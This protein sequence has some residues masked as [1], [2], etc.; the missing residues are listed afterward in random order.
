MKEILIRHVR[1]NLGMLNYKLVIEKGETILI[2]NG[3]TKKVLLD[4]I[5]VKIYAKQTWLKSKKVTIDN[6]TTELILKNDMKKG[7]IALWAMGLFNLM[8]SLSMGLW[9]DYP[10]IKTIC[11]VGCSIILLW[12]IYIFTIKRDSWI[13]IEKKMTD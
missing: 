11:I 12:V 8:L 10:T 5:P 7:M 2:R 13:L 1:Q 3:E 6:S 9:D 4:N